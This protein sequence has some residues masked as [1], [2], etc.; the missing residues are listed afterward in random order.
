MRRT[1]SPPQG[2]DSLRQTGIWGGGCP[3]AAPL[4]LTSSLPSSLLGE[5]PEDKTPCEVSTQQWDSGTLAQGTLTPGGQSLPPLSFSVR[6]R[7][8]QVVG[9]DCKEA[10]DWLCWALGAAGRKT[11]LGFSWGLPSIPGASRPCGNRSTTHCFGHLH[12]A[13][14]G[15]APCDPPLW[16]RNGF[17]RVIVPCLSGLG[18]MFTVN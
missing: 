7:T 10:S 13:H 16:L 5:C 4:P 15:L 12:R 17:L 9:A 6:E 14:Q 1:W 3:E 18:S 11:E 2:T 8:V